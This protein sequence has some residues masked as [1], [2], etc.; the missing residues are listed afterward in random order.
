MAGFSTWIPEV[1]LRDVSTDISNG[2][3]GEVLSEITGEVPEGLTEIFSEKKIILAERMPET[4]F[5]KEH[6]NAEMYQPA[7][8]IKIKKKWTSGSLKKTIWFL[9][10][11]FLKCALVIFLK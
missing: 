7:E 1:I 3:P 10:W 9:Q 6:L 8:N 5:Q 11:D 4:K 2:I